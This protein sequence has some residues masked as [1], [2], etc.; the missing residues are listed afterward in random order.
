MPPAG[1]E[2]PTGKLTAAEKALVREV[3]TPATHLVFG[4]ARAGIQHR[5]AYHA[6]SL[7]TRALMEGNSDTYTQ[8]WRPSSMRGVLVVSR[9]LLPPPEKEGKKDKAAA[10]KKEKEAKKAEK[11]RRK[12]HD[13]KASPPPLKR[14]E[15]PLPP[16]PVCLKL[17][18]LGG[19]REVLWEH[20][21]PPLHTP[22]DAGMGYK[23]EP[24]HELLHSFVTPDAIVG[25]L[26][27]NK[28]EA[29]EILRLVLERDKLATEPGARCRFPRMHAPADRRCSEEEEQDGAGGRKAV[30][31]AND[32]ARVLALEEALRRRGRDERLAAGEHRPGPPD[33]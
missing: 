23:R 17:L 2:E 21:L 1:K 18:D 31:G 26:F 20:D 32:A 22:A 7:R 13:G 11:E 9:R 29:D 27:E 8:A 25:L 10:R 33:A 12:S 15:S 6:R 28:E 14:P 30:Q 3:L 19:A 16:A 5:C 24:E 4:A